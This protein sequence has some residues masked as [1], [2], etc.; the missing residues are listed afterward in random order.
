[1]RA[2]TT[3]EY[4]GSRTARCCSSHGRFGAAERATRLRVAAVARTL[5]TGGARCAALRFHLECPTSTLTRVCPRPSPLTLH[6]SPFALRPSTGAR[7]P[8][9]P[10]GRGGPLRA[11]ARGERDAR[12][13]RGAARRR[14]VPHLR[15]RARL[16]VRAR[17]WRRQAAGHTT[18][19]ARR[20]GLLGAARGG[21]LGPPRVRDAHP[22]RADAAVATRVGAPRRARSGAARPAAAVAP[23][24]ANLPPTARRPRSTPKA[25]SWQGRS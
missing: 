6:P 21:D 19:L 22:C 15:V 23:P 13:Q 25:P 17:L 20:L 14:R 8:A 7:R 16:A 4:M 9:V 11:R 18:A 10:H 5:H 12:P 2:A 3:A 1:M 24:R